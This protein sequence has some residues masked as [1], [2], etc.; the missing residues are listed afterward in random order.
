MHFQM[1]CSLSKVKI[2]TQS[3]LSSQFIIHSRGVTLSGEAFQKENTNFISI[4]LGIKFNV[5][6]TLIN[7][8][9]EVELIQLIHNR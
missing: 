4:V 1:T 9:L 2:S 8:L 7:K 6:V 5:L 3:I